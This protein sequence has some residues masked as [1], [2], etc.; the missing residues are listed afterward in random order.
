MKNILIMGAP[1]AGKGT[2][3]ERIVDEYNIPHISTGDIFRSNIKNET[4]LGVEAK[5][6]ID[7]GQLVPDDVTNRMVEDRLGQDD[8]KNGFLLDGY[9]R[10]INQAEA[11]TLMLEKN[12]RKIDVVLNIDVA[13]EKL[14]DRLT[15]RRMCPTCGASY[16]VIFN[17]PKVEGKCDKDGAELY[18]R[19]DDNEESVSTRLEAYNTQTKPLLEYYEKYDIVS[20]V[21][22]EGDINDIFN[23]IKKV[24]NK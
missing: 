16:H 3:S 13:Q 8:C 4:P 14:L 23:D 11:L 17:Q 6:Y 5:S 19:S 2:Q 9:P 22:G 1:G 10:T 21:N 24:L 20:H 18:Q 12:N 15:G 7:K